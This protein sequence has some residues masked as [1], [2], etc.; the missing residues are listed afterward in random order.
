MPSE[1]GQP[2]GVVGSLGLTEH[3]RMIG[4]VGVW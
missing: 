4:V 2:G 1:F 3:Y